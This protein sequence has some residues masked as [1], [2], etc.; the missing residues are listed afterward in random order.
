M[1]DS[2]KMVVGLIAVVG[3]AYLAGSLF[4]PEL[5][6]NMKLTPIRFNWWRF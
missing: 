5:I 2:A 4:F 1:D 6:E 3:V